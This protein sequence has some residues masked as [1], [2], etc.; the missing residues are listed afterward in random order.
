MSFSRPINTAPQDGTIVI[1]L[2][3]T[4]DGAAVEIPMVWSRARGEWCPFQ[5]SPIEGG[6]QP[7]GWRPPADGEI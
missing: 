1:G 4:A 7:D 5:L 6:L 2:C 3:L